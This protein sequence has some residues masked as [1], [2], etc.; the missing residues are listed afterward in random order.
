MVSCGSINPSP[1]LCKPVAA[2]VL[3]LKD[4]KYSLLP[5]FTNSVYNIVLKPGNFWPKHKHNWCLMPFYQNQALHLWLIWYK[6]ENHQEY[7]VLLYWVFPLSYMD[8]IY[9]FHY[10]SSWIWSGRG[11]CALRGGTKWQKFVLKEWRNV[12]AYLALATWLCG[13]DFVKLNPW[14]KCTRV[15]LRLYCLLHRLRCYWL[16]TKNWGSYVY[17][18]FHS[19]LGTFRLLIWL[20]FLPPN[21]CKRFRNLW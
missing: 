6:Q 19:I 8:F 1:L 21:K 14:E 12:T 4:T 7:A 16:D 18:K 3:I 17:D 11:H 5:Q 2:F 20:H 9:S 15:K 13:I 10:L